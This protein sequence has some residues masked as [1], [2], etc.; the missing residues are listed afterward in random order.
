MYILLL[1]MIPAAFVLGF[2]LCALCQA[3]DAE[4]ESERI[5]NEWQRTHEKRADL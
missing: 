1:I 5:W 2:I 4:H 3:S